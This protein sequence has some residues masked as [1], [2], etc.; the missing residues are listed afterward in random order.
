LFDLRSASPTATNVPSKVQ[1]IATD[2]FDAH[3]IGSFGDG[4]VSIWDTRRLTNPLLTFSEKDA[5]ADGAR[6]KSGP[7][8]VYS[9]IEFSSI[10]RGMLATL[11]KDA[12]CVRFWDLTRTQT[13][14]WDGSSDADSAKEVSRS[15]PPRMSWATLPWTAGS[16][17]NQSQLSNKDSDAHFPEYHL[18]LSDTRR[19][20]LEI[21]LYTKIL[22]LIFFAPAKYF[23]R[24]L[25]SFALVPSTQAHP[26]TT[27]VAVVSSNKDG[28]LELHSM[29][30]A[31]KHIVWSARGDLAVTTSQ[32]LKIL[33]GIQ[34]TELP[35]EPWDSVPEYALPPFISP[36]T[37][38]DRRTA[39]SSVRLENLALPQDG[40]SNQ[41]TA[42]LAATRPGILQSYSP[43][44]LRKHASTGG[45]QKEATTPGGNRNSARHR[46]KNFGRDRIS[47]AFDSIVE[48][49]ISM[50]MR[51]RVVAGYGISDVLLLFST[52]LN[53]SNSML[54]SAKC[55][56][57]QHCR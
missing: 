12:T 17:G 10:R 14:S 28:D 48:T 49:D 20:E 2:P 56:K 15:R 9:M 5:R 46:T 38:R 1:G 25:A 7:N 55:F 3:R 8:A 33:P 53:A 4:L 37:R 27:N 13:F 45:G 16:S 44:S 43:A 34:Q 11:E 29:H 52:R 35:T 21:R 36:T 54:V 50:T 42:N 19:C 6:V 26:F 51:R 30:D 32:T 24:P 47:R 40:L 41:F 22:L 39:P 18:V 57:H 23:N 31:P